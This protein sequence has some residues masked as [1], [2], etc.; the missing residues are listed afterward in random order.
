MGG[1]FAK[2][3]EPSP[4]GGHRETVPSASG[5]IPSAAAAAPPPAEA[6]GLPESAGLRDEAFDCDPMPPVPE[7]PLTIARQFT[8]GNARPIHSASRRDA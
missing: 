1:E 4:G 3:R 7:G 5:V 2:A 8:G 6:G